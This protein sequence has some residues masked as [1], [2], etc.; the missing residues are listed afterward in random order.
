[1][2][3]IS[4]NVFLNGPFPASFCF[5]FVFSIQLTKTMFKINF[6]DDGI[7]T[8]DL[9]CQKQLLRQLSHNHCPYNVSFDTFY[10]SSRCHTTSVTRQGD[11]LDFGQVLKPL[12]TISLPKSTTFL[13]TIFAEV[14]KSLHFSSGIIFGQL[15]WTFCNFLLVTLAHSQLVTM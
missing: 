11:L 5:I 8:A 4:Y 3:E 6:A 9:R 7:R 2:A 14:S 15:L 12:A 1:M 10:S 13:E